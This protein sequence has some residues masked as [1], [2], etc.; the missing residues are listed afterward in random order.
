[1]NSKKVL[2]ISLFQLL[3]A[4][5]PISRRQGEE[6]GVLMGEAASLVPAFLLGRIFKNLLQEQKSK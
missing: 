6:N 3:F 2:L 5:E 4:L 1:M